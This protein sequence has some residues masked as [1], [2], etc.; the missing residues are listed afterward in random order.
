[1]TPRRAPPARPAPLA[2]LHDPLVT[3][4]TVAAA[5]ELA[6][7]ALLDHALDV[8]RLAL[9]A[10]QPSLVGEPPPW[11]VTTELRAATRV[12]R[13]ALAL[14]RAAAAYRRAVLAALHDGPASDNDVPC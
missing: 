1:M 2:R 13:A 3:P 10:A 7:L 5:P 8:T 4:E 11:R 6:V 12:L 14:E 9:L